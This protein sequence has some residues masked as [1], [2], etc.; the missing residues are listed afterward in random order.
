MN[1]RP[2]TLLEA[3]GG[4][5]SLRLVADHLADGIGPHLARRLVAPVHGTPRQLSNLRGG[6]TGIRLV[7]YLTQYLGYATYHFPQLHR[8]ALRALMVGWELRQL[9]RPL[10]AELAGADVIVAMSAFNAD[11]FAREFPTTPVVL[12][13]LLPPAAGDVQPSRRRFGLPEDHTVV[14]SAFD[15]ISG[16]DRKDPTSVLDAFTMA[17][18]E[19][20]D[21]SLVFKTHGLER[22]TAL[23][24][25]HPEGQRARDF[26]DRCAA[27]PRVILFDRKLPYH[28]VQSLVK[29]AD[30]YI[31][32]ARAEG[33]GLPVLE[34]MSLDVATICTAYSG[35]LDFATP[36]SG[37]LVDV[38]EVPLTD[39]TS[40][41]YRPDLFDEQP[42]WGTG[43][44]GAGGLPPRRPRKLTD[45]AS[46]G[47]CRRA[48]A[49]RTLRA[50]QSAFGVG[51]RSCG[52][53]HEH[54]SHG[55]SRQSASGV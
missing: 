5:T 12:A 46:R 51:R 15:P 24:P 7:P 21:V 44:F 9:P 17:F 34:A 43:R 40:H 8:D 28:Q 31:S 48:R 53:R 10:K 32:L 54:R 55:A 11:A 14:L 27:D 39:D 26:I 18:G 23:P 13:P 38:T 50:Q 20:N 16:F 2:V 45:D 25:D 47:S 4:S 22:I 42:V 49:G 19:R 30:I 33:F 29:S 35:H 52:I 6:Y 41:H 37:M 36:N 3:V 1:Q